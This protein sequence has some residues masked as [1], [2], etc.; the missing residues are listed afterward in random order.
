MAGH[1]SFAQSQLGATCFSLIFWK[2]L[3]PMPKLMTVGMVFWWETSPSRVVAH[4]IRP[5]RRIRSVWML[6]SGYAPCPSAAS[7]K[8]SAKAS[9]PFSMLKSG[10]RSVDPNK[11]T[12]AHFRL[13]KRAASTPGVAR[14]FVHPGI[15]KALVQHGWL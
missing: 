8:E 13:I 10:T 11:F 6:I 14:I 15:K 2:S 4:D 7:R 1:A 5:W 12:A 3:L 9:P